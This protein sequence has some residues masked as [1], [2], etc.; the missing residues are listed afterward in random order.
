MSNF[1]YQ[2][3]TTGNVT[4]AALGSTPKGKYIA[5]SVSDVDDLF[6]VHPNYGITGFTTNGWQ[7][8]NVLNFKNT[9]SNPVSVKRDGSLTTQSC[10]IYYNDVEQTKF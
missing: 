4:T 5:L 6:E 2:P 1:F 10:R 3:N 9:T 7:G 8:S